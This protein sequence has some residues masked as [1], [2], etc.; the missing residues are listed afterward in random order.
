MKSCR[1][2][3]EHLV[4]SVCGELSSQRRVELKDHLESCAGCS[5]ELEGLRA[6]VEYVDGALPARSQ[7]PQSTVWSRLLPELEKLEQSPV[8]HMTLGFPA[9]GAIAAAILVV[10]IALG[11]L[12]RPANQAPAD[13]ASR[14]QAVASMG[15]KSS[16]AE[17]DAE[18]VRYLERATPLLLAIANRQA[19][20]A[21]LASLE[22][23]TERRLAEELATEAERLAGL[24]DAKGRRRQAALTAEL[25]AV[26]LQMSNLPSATYRH[27]IEVVQATIKSRALLFQLSV[28]EMRRL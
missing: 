3:R 8:R 14:V 27:G 2:W 6:T 24:L 10:G 11:V 23:T 26:F 15:A 5:A 28:E 18:F 9:A 21:D 25:G 4:E 17:I 13:G 19:T 16:G 12:V 7:I 20:G 1:R 22:A